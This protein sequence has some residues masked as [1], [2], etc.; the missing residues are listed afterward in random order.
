MYIYAVEN[1]NYFK[2]NVSCELC[3][4][5]II[6]YAKKPN[7]KTNLS[8]KLCNFIEN[9]KHYI[10]NNLSHGDVV[11]KLLKKP[12]QTDNII[13]FKNACLLLNNVNI[14][15]N[16]VKYYKIDDLKLFRFK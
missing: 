5:C 11:F 13:I 8:K 3:T 14:G 7:I 1:N 12:E 4:K 6:D 16:I 10:S 15:Q 2:F 9:N